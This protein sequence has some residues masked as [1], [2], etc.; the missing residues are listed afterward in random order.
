MLTT[1]MMTT[2]MM[3][4]IALIPDWET[5]ILRSYAAKDQHKPQSL[6]TMGS[7]R[8]AGNRY[9]GRGHRFEFIDATTSLNP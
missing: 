4:M 3:T 8:G 6:R 5:S 9:S 7:R 2:M 1:M